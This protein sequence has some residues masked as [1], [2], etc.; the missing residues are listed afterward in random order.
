MRNY[1]KL[2]LQL[3]QNGMYD[4]VHNKKYY[5]KKIMLHFSQ[6]DMHCLV[7]LILGMRVAVIELSRPIS[8]S[9]MRQNLMAELI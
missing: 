8:E 4:K 6:E 9:L 7:I 5:L 3:L 2:I 1:G